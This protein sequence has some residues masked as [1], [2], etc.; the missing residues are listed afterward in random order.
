MTADAAP[1]AE[2]RAPRG[3]RNEGRRG[4]SPRGEREQ[5]PAALPVAEEAMPAAQPFVDTMPGATPDAANEGGERDASRR[6]RRRG[7][8]GRG[9]DEGGAEGAVNAAS[10]DGAGREPSD[11]PATM[12]AD[13]A[14]NDAPYAVEYEAAEPQ[15]SEAVAA[16][17]KV[18]TSIAPMAAAPVAAPVPPQPVAVAIATPVAAAPYHLPTET[19]A[20]IAS[21]AGLQWVNSDTEKIRAVQEAMANEPRPIQA[22]R[23]PKPRAVADDGPL[24]LVETKKDL[25]QIKLPFDGS[26]PAAH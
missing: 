24:V 19:L 16:P 4:G 7:G 9:R 18:S 2:V 10:D 22:P 20:A 12:A 13:A 15:L 5:R 17:L 3:E 14:V 23:Q 11:E 6:R 8:R 25:S 26:G 21:Q 1:V